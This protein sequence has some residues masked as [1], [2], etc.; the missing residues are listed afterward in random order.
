MQL[1]FVSGEVLGTGLDNSSHLF[2]EGI[3]K[4]DVADNPTL[5]EGKRPD[6]FR[7]VNSLIWNYEVHGLNLLPQGTDSREGNDASDAEMTKGRNVGLVWDL[8]GRKLMVGAMASE[9]GDV[10]IAMAENTD[11]RRWRAPWSLRIDCSNLMKAFKLGEAGAADNGDLDGDLERSFSIVLPRAREGCG[12]QGLGWWRDETE[13]RKPG[14]HSPQ[15]K[16]PQ[17]SRSER[18]GLMESE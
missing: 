10:G 13:V 4:A 3:C 5:E 6:A 11:G 2:I 7:A 1:N 8:V 18:D 9:E 15:Q 17:P 14:T 16:S 12:Q